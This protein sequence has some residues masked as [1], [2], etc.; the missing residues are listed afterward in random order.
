[1]PSCPGSWEVIEHIHAGTVMGGVT[2]FSSPHAPREISDWRLGSSRLYL[3]KTR[4]GSA[5]SRPMIKTR[6]RA[7]DEGWVA[8]DV[9]LVPYSVSS[10]LL[11][12]AAAPLLSS[13][14]FI[15]SISTC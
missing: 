7:G 3:S 9:V 10:L 4:L 12:L 8:S 5:Q 6:L 14:A 1:M 11:P 2:L 15:P 13:R